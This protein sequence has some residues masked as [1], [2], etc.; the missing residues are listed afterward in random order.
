MNI[1]VVLV[2]FNRL[3]DL[4]KTLALYEVQSKAPD[5]ILV[6]NNNSTDGT[7]VFLEKWKKEEKSIPHTVVTLPE[8][9]GG[10]GGFH[11]GA[12]KA[13][14]LDAEWIWM[15]DDDAFPD[16]NALEALENFSKQHEEVV[17][18]AAA[19][20]TKNVGRNGIGQGHRCRV[21]R[22][23]LGTFIVPVLEEEYQKDYFELDIYSFVG[24][25]VKKEV[26]QKA[27]LPD[28][29][30]FIYED[31]VEHSLRVRACGTIICVPEA[32]ITHYENAASNEASWRDY[33]TTRNVLLT[34]KYHFDTYA[35][36]VRLICRFLTACRSLNPEKLEIFFVAARDAKNGVKGIHPV[37][38]PGWKP[39]HKS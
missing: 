37:Y 4:K 30:F 14:E 19:L 22:T 24:A 21:K 34:Y 13:L 25:V 3:N 36:G 31:D 16:E 5:Y 32:K 1:G 10:S 39:R 7:D 26:M 28:K 8:N 2:T 23:A 11:Y 6:V 27:G 35:Y 20:C 15:A 18:G 29:D 9:I 33:Y 38:R 17:R 12:K